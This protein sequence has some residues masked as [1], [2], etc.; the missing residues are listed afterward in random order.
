MMRVLGLDPGSATVG[1]GIVEENQG[2]ITVVAYGAITTSP[3]DGD[4]ARRLQLIYEATNELIATHKPDAAA[5]EELFFGRNITTAIKVGQ[6]RGVL[7]LA[8]ANA[9]LPLAEYSPPKIK[10]AVAG[11]GNAS[12]EQVQF[13]V[14]NLL[15]LAETPRP[16]D[17][18]DGLAVALTYCQYQRQER[19]YGG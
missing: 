9:D 3:Q 11:Y 8:L 14:T 17:A 15:N 19:L 16:D 1:Y 2:E 6:A 13:M 7:L 18:A 10:E 4:S 12:K 5:V